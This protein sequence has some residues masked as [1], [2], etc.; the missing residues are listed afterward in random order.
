MKNVAKYPLFAALLG[1]SLTACEKKADPQPAAPKTQVTADA[2]GESQLRTNETLTS[3]QFLIT[4]DGKYRLVMQ[5]D[6]NLVLYRTADNRALWNTGTQGNPGAR[7]I[8]QSDGNFVVY[9]TANA[10]VYASG[11]VGIN[12]RT[13]LLVLV[14][15]NGVGL[16]I[17][18]NGTIASL[19]SGS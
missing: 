8:M 2:S 14:S 19:Y 17:I 1:L 6:G 3:E 15:N 11:R 18:N 13:P 10:P 4:S 9:N 7:C 16:F 12:G 5:G